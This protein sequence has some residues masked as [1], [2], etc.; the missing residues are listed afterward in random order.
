MAFYRSAINL[1]CSLRW[2]YIL[3]IRLYCIER[4]IQNLFSVQ[5]QLLFFL[6]LLI[7]VQLKFYL[8]WIVRRQMTSS[9]ST[10]TTTIVIL[11]KKWATCTQIGKCAWNKM[12]VKHYNRIMLFAQQIESQKKC[13]FISSTS[14]Q[15]VFQ[16][17]QFSMRFKTR[18]RWMWLPF[19]QNFT[20]LN[21]TTDY[22]LGFLNNEEL[23]PLDS[24]L[25]FN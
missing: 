13:S 14:W 6:S 5:R 19:S 25:L 11:L 24:N 3:F 15:I 12:C 7:F 9:S 22:F 16:F 8:L 21:V 17:V 10:T 23:K 2:H 18:V 20:I 1:H 4:T